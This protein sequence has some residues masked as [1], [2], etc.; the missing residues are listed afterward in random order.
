M[1]P[2]PAKRIPKNREQFFEVYQNDTLNLQCDENHS[3]REP[4]DRNV[5]FL[6][7]PK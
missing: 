5:E 7:P 1:W 6:S 4:I 3:I 2:Q